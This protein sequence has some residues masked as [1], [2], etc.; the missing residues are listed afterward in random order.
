MTP[1]L[2]TCDGCGATARWDVRW[3]WFGSYEEAEACE[4]IIRLCRPACL[5]PVQARLGRRRLPDPPADAL[6]DWQRHAAL[7]DLAAAIAGT[8]ERLEEL[9]QA[10][11]AREVGRTWQDAEFQVAMREAAAAGAIR[12]IRR[13]RGAVALARPQDRAA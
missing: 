3:R 1:R 13:R 11:A 8:V 12:I 10:E 4:P 9:D 5:Q 2:H 6:A 7:S